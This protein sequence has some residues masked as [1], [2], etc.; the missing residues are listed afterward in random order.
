MYCF[1]CNCYICYFCYFSVLIVDQ[2][3]S[4]LPGRHL[5]I[6]SV[7]VVI[8]LDRG[9]VSIVWEEHRR[10]QTLLL[11]PPKTGWNGEVTLLIKHLV[12][13]TKHRVV[14]AE[15]H[16]GVSVVQL[17]ADTTGSVAVTSCVDQVDSLVVSHIGSPA[18][19]VSSD[20]TILNNCDKNV[21]SGWYH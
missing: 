12:T 7:G 18:V 8:P 13:L 9:Q 3:A 6:V 19:G 11:L 1:I 5:S 15:Q 14:T 21:R 17:H 2:D 10:H 16:P 20:V 4:H